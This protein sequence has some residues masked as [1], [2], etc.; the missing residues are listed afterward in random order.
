MC[1]QNLTR[2][3]EFLTYFN[4]MVIDIKAI[5]LLTFLDNLQ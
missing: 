1:F 2:K 4:F 5:I 3:T